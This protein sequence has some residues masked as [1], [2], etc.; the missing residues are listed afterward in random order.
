MRLLILG[1]PVGPSE[2]DSRTAYRGTYRDRPSY[3]DSLP[4]THPVNVAFFWSI[5]K[6]PARAEDAEFDLVY[7]LDKARDLVTAYSRDAAQQF[8]VSKSPEAKK[9]PKLARS[10]WASICRGSSSTRSCGMAWRYATAPRAG[11]T[12]SAKTSCA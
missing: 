12:R 2:G 1:D 6:D 8:E 11:G 4:D 7:D 9:R 3:V 5:E 10:S